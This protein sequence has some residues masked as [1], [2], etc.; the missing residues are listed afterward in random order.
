MEARNRKVLWVGLASIVLLALLAS[1]SLGSATAGLGT[2]STATTGAVIPV[3]GGGTAT[4][5]VHQQT[6]AEPPAAVSVIQDPT[7]AALAAQQRVNSGENYAFDLFERPFSQDMRTYF[8]DLDI[9]RAEYSKDGT[10]AYISIQLGG[11]DPKNGGLA[12][13]YGVELDTNQDGRG[14]FLVVVTAPTGTSWSSNGVK[15]YSDGSQEVG[16]IHP[17]QADTPPQ[18]GKGYGTLLDDSGAGSDP[19]LAFARVSPSD[20]NTVQLAFKWS[21][22]NGSSFVWG[23]WAFD[24]SMFH[25]DWFDYDDHFTQADAGSPIKELAQF[26]PLK[27]L[28]LMDNTCRWGAGFTP[29]AGVPGICPLP[30]TPVPPAAPAPGRTLIFLPPPVFFIPTPTQVILR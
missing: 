11:P 21:L 18:T 27:Q 25:A 17:V 5:V 7:D 19:D 29:S 16:G 1:C 9:A 22:A 30:A 24:P 3:T 12:G 6:P 28:Y 2:G 13:T 20:P 23:A 4:P 26:Y 15:V 14:D 10:W 8:P